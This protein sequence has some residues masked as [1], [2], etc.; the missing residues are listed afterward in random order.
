MQRLRIG[1]LGLQP[2]MMAA[3]LLVGLLLVVLTVVVGGSFL[4]IVSEADLVREQVVPDIGRQHR[5]AVMAAELSRLAEIILHS[6][7]AG[8]RGQAL[9]EAETLTGRFAAATGDPESRIDRA[10]HAVRRSAYRADQIDA[11]QSAIDATIQRSQE[12][13]RSLGREPS[14][15]MDALSAILRRHRLLQDAERADNRQVDDIE[16]EYWSMAG[17]LPADLQH[18]TFAGAFEARREILRVRNEAES[19]GAVAQ[20]ELREL[21][22]G[23]SA[24]AANQTRGMA[25]AIFAYARHGLMVSGAGLAVTGAVLG[26]L[27]LLL[28]RH[29]VIPLRWAAHALEEIRQ[30]RPC[31]PLSPASLREID[32]LS[33]TVA[34]FGAV[35]NELQGQAHVDP[36]TG[37]ANRRLLLSH[38]GRA[39]RLAQRSG[40][41]G[42][43]L[44]L[45]LDGFKQV[46]D[47]L[48]HRL[49]DQLLI[50]V[51]A[52]IAGCMRASDLVSRVG[53]D[54][55]ALVM[56]DIRGLDDAIHL[57]DRI[58]AALSQPFLDGRGRIGVSIGV[59][60][61]PTGD[62]SC[63]TLLQ[64]ADAAMYQAKRAGKNCYR[65]WDVA[66]A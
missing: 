18:D 58:I 17:Q 49:G 60:V 41:H 4:W 8:L 53:G 3:L 55:F 12:Q 38:L 14:P 23:L 35:L 39:L 1:T 48:G 62:D 27:G 46:N 63:E 5:E 57:A 11:L 26:T 51:A 29:V 32:D 40:W 47:N 59:V 22:D 36:L 21:S 52:R 2:A 6:R 56:D 24:D 65:V 15:R 37:L 44:Y 50:D 16:F 64:N 43:V 30:N 20:H 54:E 66:L 25:D 33:Q 13:L 7:D 45:D 31:P 34:R 28:R 42:A 61:F 10:M 9:L 19:D